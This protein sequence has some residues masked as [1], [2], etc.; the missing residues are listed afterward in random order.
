M[1]VVKHLRYFV[2][3]AE[4]GHVGRA[5]DRLGI[6]QPA[7]TQRMRGLQTSLGVRLL[8]RSGR[9][10]GL[11]DAGRLLAREA[12][13]ALAELDELIDRLRR[14]SLPAETPWTISVPATLS[15][16]RLHELTRRLDL[17]VAPRRCVL[18]AGSPE[19]R[20]DQ[21]TGA[22]ADAAMLVVGDAGDLQVPLGAALA[23]DHPLSTMPEVHPRDLREDG[24]MILD[25]DEPTREL[26]TAQLV[27]QGLPE[28][29]IEPVAT[30]IAP[31]RVLS[32]T[33]CLT[34]RVH[35]VDLG[36]AWLPLTGETIRR[37]YRVDSPLSD[38]HR[39]ISL[40]EEISAT[41]GGAA[42]TPVRPPEDS[43]SRV[44]TARITRL[45]D[46]V[47]VQ[48]SLHAVDLE[49]GACIEIAGDAV[50]LLASVSKVALCVAAYRAEARGAVDL[51]R[52]VR[53]SSDGRASGTT[54]ISIMND[55][56]QLS[57]RDAMQL[58]LI[59]SDNAAADGLWDAIGPD[60]LQESLAELPGL[61]GLTLGEPFRDLYDRFV[62][63][64]QH[65]DASTANRGSARQMTTLLGH[66][67]HDRAADPTA[68]A[69]LRD[70]MSRQ[71]WRQRLR[72]GFPLDNIEVAGKTGTFGPY[73]HEIGV[74]SFPDRRCYAVA[75]MTRDR[76]AARADQVDRAIGE[77]A[78]LAVAGLRQQPH[79]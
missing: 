30:S 34:D 70:L 79:P 5:A 53:L 65:P 75:V 50:W 61:A 7:L 56:V 38:H 68:C 37:H 14:F 9:G 15:A 71:L 17:L 51:S 18:T 43:P 47:G 32:G 66:I 21:L 45:W 60:R 44:A 22:Q 28:G 78:R 77:S 3:V 13:G 4:E 35:A 48:G 2:V 74:I 64:E 20:R 55:E 24:L 31:A 6:A 72:S 25:E 8:E 36:L 62:I 57:L 1:D 23:P 33:A 41:F 12:P 42:T 69:Q 16:A 40:V 46:D 67:W 54:G 73:R 59:I 10:I 49:T 27:R 52:L 11:T 39:R 76:G 26:I 58:A 19:Q 63:T 29:R